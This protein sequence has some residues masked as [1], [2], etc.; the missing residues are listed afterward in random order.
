MPASRRQ[1]G[2]AIVLTRLLEL[3]DQF[4]TW[5]HF[6][7]IIQTFV[8]V[9]DSMTFLQLKD[10]MTA[11]GIHTLADVASAADIGN[12]QARIEQGELGVQNIRGDAFMSPPGAQLR[13][14]RSFTVFGQKFVIDAWAQSKV[15]YDDIIW[16]TNKVAR[17]V[18]SALDVAFSVLNNRHIVPELVAR[19]TNSAARTNGDHTLHFRD[20]YNYQHNLAA[21]REVITGLDTNYWSSNIYLS[22]LGCLR[23]LSRPT[24][25]TFYP[26]AMRTRA[27]A[28]RTLNTQLASW[29]QL[30]HDTV[31][32]V[33]QPYTDSGLCSYP[34]AFVEPRV[35]FWARLEQMATNTA[36]VV[37]TLP[38]QGTAYLQNGFST[39]SYDLATIKSNQVTF[40]KHFAT[41][42][43][44]LREIAEQHTRH[45]PLSAAQLQFVNDMMQ[46]VSSN[47]YY[48][49]RTYTGWYPGLF[50]R[51]SVRIA[52]DSGYKYEYEYGA[53]K[54]DALVTDVHTDPPS[55]LHNDPGG[56]L[57]QAVGKVHL[58]YI[59]VDDGAKLT[60]YAGPVFSHYEFETAF[61]TRLTD[62]E[63][64][65]M[66]ANGQEPPHP[67]WTR[68]WL[69]PAE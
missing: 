9:T 8:G 59:V 51:H 47:N 6:D 35:T 63:W 49:I 17:R 55:P 2:T 30:R 32:Y 60:T 4:E 28:L 27:W 52:W 14:P 39:S 57:H 13:L 19:M 42:I 50:Y 7:T 29:T 53:T 61:P 41:Q 34:D 43:G 36:N 44:K 16:N 68:T 21:V 3:A 64:K 40:L 67:D 48:R 65:G 11:A 31:L 24:T 10:L 46:N 38:Y 20:G 56:I 22:W 1:L 26:Q 37:K 18:T 58:L 23:E 12:F 33:K 45:E 54:Y 25:H 69:V 66:L 5:K 62:A 15:V